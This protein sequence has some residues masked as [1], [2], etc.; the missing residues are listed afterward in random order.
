[1]IAPEGPIS[2]RFS[3]PI[4]IVCPAYGVDE[5]AQVLRKAVEDGSELRD[6]V[7]FPVGLVPKPQQAVVATE[8]GS[9]VVEA[10]PMAFIAWRARGGTDAAEEEAG[11]EGRKEEER[12]PIRGPL[13]REPE[14]S[15]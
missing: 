13:G 6:V 15:R 11:Q 7:V 14:A 9:P 12:R 10:E 3:G 8:G 5:I 4:R 2:V 1:M